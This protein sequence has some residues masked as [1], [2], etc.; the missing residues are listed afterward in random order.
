MATI[1]EELQRANQYHRAGCFDQAKQIYEQILKLQPEHPEALYGLGILAQQS[2]QLQTAEELLRK[3]LQ[4]KPDYLN[5]RINL[6]NLLQEQH[7]FTAAIEC[8]QQVLQLKPNL[9]SVY[10]NLGYIQ[11]QQGDLTYAIASYQK[12]LELQP[13]CTEAEINLGNALY[14]QGKLASEKYAH[15][16][17]LNHQLGMKL[18]QTGDLDAAITCYQQAIALQPDLAAYHY[19]LGVALQR[20]NKCPEAIAAYEQVL[21]LEPSNGEVYF[22]LGKIY[23]KQHRLQESA[24]AYR[25]GLILLNPHYA[26]AVA[27]YKGTDTPPEERVPPEVRLGEVKVGDYNFPA[28]PPLSVSEKPRP[29]WSIIVPLYNR[30]DYLLE[31]LANVLRQWQGEEDMEILVMDNASTPPLFELVEAIGGGVV[32]YYRN[33]QNLGARRNFNLGIALSRGH[34]IHLL[35]EDEYV[36]P[37]FYAQLKQSL[38][39]CPDSIGAAFTGY[40]NLNEKGEV[41]FSQTHTGMHEGINQDW[42]WRIGTANSLNPCAV[43][44]RRSAHQRLGGYDPGNTYTPDWEL[45][46]R[47]AVFYDWWFEPGIWAIYRQHSHNMTSELAAVGAQAASI[48]Q[49]IEIS[50]SYLPAE[51]CA[52]ITANARQ[53]Y[54]DYCL[55]QTAI[56]LQAG[57]LDGAFRLVQE[58]LKIDSST[59]AEEK[60]FSWLNQ[61]QATPLRKAIASNLRSLSLPENNISES[62][63]FAYP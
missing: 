54:F 45:Y 3:T 29:F 44:I 30:T 48:R 34:W 35:P 25:Q 13:N 53:Y 63:Y 27:D 33:P 57:N 23:Q 6:G 28:I 50:Q 7:Q 4:L 41:I 59:Q 14:R 36:L 12:A 55:Q 58:A 38:A 43:V 46:K 26:K 16:A 42:L 20:Q 11:Q 60:F 56:P 40:A 18:Q 1:S 15:Y 19:N 32:R 2:G 8:Y 37:G 17:S 52:E 61:E 62:F 51:Y 39:E 31:C 49:G 5:A 24:A 22:N 21:K 10:N 47:I 9:A